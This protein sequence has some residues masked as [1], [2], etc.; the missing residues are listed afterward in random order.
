[1]Q[2]RKIKFPAFHQVP[3]NLG[4]TYYIHFQYDGHPSGCRVMRDRNE[5]QAALDA[6]ITGGPA[7]IVVYPGCS[8]C[9]GPTP[10]LRED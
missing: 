9:G 10:C 2:H 4:R 1:M 7:V 8:L 6:A 5:I 3:E